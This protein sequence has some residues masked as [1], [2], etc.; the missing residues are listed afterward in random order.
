MTLEKGLALSSVDRHDLK[1]IYVHWQKVN[2]GFTLLLSSGKQSTWTHAGINQQICTYFLAAF[3]S[4][5]VENGRKSFKL[6]LVQF[7]LY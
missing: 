4:K 6:V 5:P 3:T 1:S 7:A 2:A